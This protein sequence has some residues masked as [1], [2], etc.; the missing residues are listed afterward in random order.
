MTLIYVGL[1]SIDSPF[2]GCTTHFTLFLIR[3]LAKRDIFLNA[4]PAL[5]RLNP[6]IPLKT[7]GNAA[8]A[9]V[10][11]SPSGQGL[12]NLA[13]DI[14]QL[15]S[16]Y[17]CPVGGSCKSSGYGLVIT[18]D[19]NGQLKAFLR[20]L[21]YKALT[22]V[23]DHSLVRDKLLDLGK[24]DSIIV[25]GDRGIVGAAAAL[26]FV[27]LDEKKVTFEL[28][29]YR[30]P[31][32]YGKNRDVDEDSLKKACEYARGRLFNNYDFFR[33]RAVALP[34]G[35]DPVLIGL[36]GTDACTL[37]D[38]A[39]MIKINEPVFSWFIY[40]TNQ[41]TDAHAVRRNIKDLRP[42]QAALVKGVVVDNPRTSTG[43]HTEFIISDLTGYV[44]VM[45]FRP[46]GPVEALA[47]M[48]NRGDHV[49]IIGITKPHPAR[50]TRLFLSAHKIIV[51]EAPR[52][53]EVK[54][55][56]CPV[57]GKT[58]KSSGRVGGFK[59]SRC[60][61]QLP[62]YEARHRI[63]LYKRAVTVGEW[64]IPRPGYIS[65]LVMPTNLSPPIAR[66]TEFTKCPWREKL[67][68]LLKGTIFNPFH[69]T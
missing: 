5:V 49:E 23:I 42:Y 9:L 34:H 43:G 57:C 51:L 59:C 50:D 37:L 8:I 13:E 39:R 69:I 25:H 40:A 10:F 14:K 52:Y 64:V 67:E 46:S 12:Y 2:G 56:A 17:K 63:K 35:P 41:H 6:A 28:I 18:S 19:G 36:R 21:Y 27:F 45:A 30:V 15:V 47:S 24:R 53:V 54:N 3:Y 26:G 33:K 55:P 11:E 32:N 29:G 65:H 7:R 62:F 60:G 16:K 4:M 58:M 66:G 20:S 48:L 31:E 22:D 68:L 1:D 61:Y 44:K 38:A